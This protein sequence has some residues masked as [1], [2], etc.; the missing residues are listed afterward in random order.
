[1]ES[2]YQPDGWLGIMI[3]ARLYFDFSGKYEFKSKA[4]ELLRQLGRE[5]NKLKDKSLAS[6]SSLKPSLENWTKEDIKIWINS[7]N[8]QH[9][10][11]NVSLYKLSN[12]DF[13]L[14]HIV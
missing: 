5:P 2:S 7:N 9:L 10:Y 11:V 12:A 3:G 4:N 14:S 8:L 13:Y 1:M 6:N